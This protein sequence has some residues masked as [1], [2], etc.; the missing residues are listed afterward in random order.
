MFFDS[1]IQASEVNQFTHINFLF[2]HTI[3]MPEDFYFIKPPK[4]IIS[5]VLVLSEAPTGISASSLSLK[6]ISLSTGSGVNYSSI[7]T[8]D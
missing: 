5:W 7:R 3:K 6:Q 1:I 4:D 8:S 2:T